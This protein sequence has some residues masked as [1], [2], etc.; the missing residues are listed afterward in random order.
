MDEWV[1]GVGEGVLVLVT[2]LEVDRWMSVIA[3]GG[4]EVGVAGKVATGLD[5]V[6]VG[7]GGMGRKWGRSACEQIGR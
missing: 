4:D 6:V 1:D 5:L 3:C 7:G 2:G